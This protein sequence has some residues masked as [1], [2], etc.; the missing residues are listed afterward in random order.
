ML[1]STP[2]KRVGACPALKTEYLPAT[3]RKTSGPGLGGGPEKQI[4]ILHG[5]AVKRIR[6]DFCK[7]L[8]GV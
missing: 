1:E 8:R 3:Q 4:I 6:S 2:T 5:A 7:R